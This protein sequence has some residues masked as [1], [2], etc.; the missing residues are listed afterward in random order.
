M[1]VTRLAVLFGVGV[2]GFL[3]Y[4]AINGVPQVVPVVIT[5]FAIL[6]LIVFGN[7][8]GGGRR[9]GRSGSGGGRPRPGGPGA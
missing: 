7:L 3:T 9:P 5:A 1:I 4:L 2:L 6:A 8:L